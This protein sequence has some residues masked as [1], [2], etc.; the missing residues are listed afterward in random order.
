MGMRMHRTQVAGMVADT[1]FMGWAPLFSRPRIFYAVMKAA[2]WRMFKQSIGRTER[3]VMMWVIAA[4]L[5]YFHE[6]MVELVHLLGGLGGLYSQLAFLS[7]AERRGAMLINRMVVV[8]LAMVM[9]M[10]GR[11]RAMVAVLPAFDHRRRRRRMKVQQTL[12]ELP[13]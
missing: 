10:V 12:I 3:E 1:H 9:V 6:L 5:G 2:T 11:R 4:A 8:V 13:R 7:T